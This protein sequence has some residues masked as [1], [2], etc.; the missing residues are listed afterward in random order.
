MKKLAINLIGL[1]LITGFVTNTATAQWGI[2][3][4]YEI[5]NESPKNGFGVR[6]EKGIFSSVPLLD[7]QIRGHFSSF[8]EENSLTRLGVTFDREFDVYDFGVALVAGV[9]L[10]VVKPYVG[11][12]LG[13]ERYRFDS[14]NNSLSII[15]G[16]FSE[17]N[18]Y[19]N[20]FGGAEVTLLPFLKPFIEFRY[21]KLFETDD[22][23]F[24]QVS[25]LAIGVNLRF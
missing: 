24:D 23:E 21:S 10:G 22:L 7:F 20:G 9:N 6:V 16:S 1:F 5:R 3:A 14:I 11:A 8:S 4:S 17:S 18:Y 25:R 19:W 13:S 15:D 12:G 2:G